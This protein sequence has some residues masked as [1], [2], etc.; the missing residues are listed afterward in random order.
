MLPQLGEASNFVPDFSARKCSKWVSKILI[1]IVAAGTEI[2]Y[3]KI[4]FKK[5]WNIAEAVVLE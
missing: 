2:I 3:I 1:S 5:C 4:H